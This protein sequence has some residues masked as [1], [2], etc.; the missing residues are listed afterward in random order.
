MASLKHSAPTGAHR[1][2]GALDTSDPE[3]A[4]ALADRPH[5]QVGRVKVGLELYTTAGGPAEAVRGGP[6]SLLVG[7]PVT[8]A[9]DPSAAACRLA[10]ETP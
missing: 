7:R 3:A 2:I 8:Q 5:G 10:A 4:L 6:D 1:F 9:A